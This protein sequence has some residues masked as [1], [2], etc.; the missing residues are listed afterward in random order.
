MNL[1][2]LFQEKREETRKR[3]VGEIIEVKKSFTGGKLQDGFEVQKE[4]NK[5]SSE[6]FILFDEG[7]G[8]E[9]NSVE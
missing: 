1:R 2:K 4:L 5:I 6:S 3:W 9:S 7:S 8:S